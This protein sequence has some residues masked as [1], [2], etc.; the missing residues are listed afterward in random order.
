ML[1]NSR[2]YYNFQKVLVHELEPRLLPPSLFRNPSDLELSE[3]T[4]LALRE[5]GM[6]Q[7]VN[8]MVGRCR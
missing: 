1:E 8:L 5:G 6:V 3:L 4:V 2:R 7:T